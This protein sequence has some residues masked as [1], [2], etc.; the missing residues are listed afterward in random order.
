MEKRVVA[1][2]KVCL[3]RRISDSYKSMPD[4]NPFLAPIGA[5]GKTVSMSV[6]EWEFDAEDEADVRRLLDE[7]YD[8]QVPGV[9]GYT[10]RSIER[11]PETVSEVRK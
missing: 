5:D 9:I 2:F 7:A 10:L 6:R 1:R 8:A 11:V 4:P 3:H